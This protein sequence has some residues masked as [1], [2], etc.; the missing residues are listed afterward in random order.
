V[1]DAFERKPRKIF[2]TKKGT[3]NKKEKMIYQAYI[4]D[5]CYSEQIREG[6]M[7]AKYCTVEETRN[8]LKILI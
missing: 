4:W 1:K 7:Y 6:V 8:V 5:Y 3:Q 2:G